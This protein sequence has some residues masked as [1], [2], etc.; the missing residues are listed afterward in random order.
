M[1]VGL[2]VPT[3]NA[4]PA[5][6]DWLAGLARQSRQPDRALVI[7]S[8]SDDDTAAL[9]RAAGLEVESIDRREFDHGGT[10]QR[11][12]DRLADCAVV[13]CLTQDAILTDPTSLA[14][15]LKV[16]D[17]PAVGAAWGRQLPHADAT[18]VAAHARAFNYPAQSRIVSYDD[19]H[20]Y[21]IKTA[22]CSN[23]FAAWRREALDA[24]GGFPSATLLAEDMFACARLLKAGWRVAYVAD[25]TVRHSHNFGWLAEFRRYFDTGATHASEDWL[26]RE[27]GNAGGEG[28]R[29][30]R[31]E[32]HFL[33]QHGWRWRL[34]AVRQLTAKWVGYKL[35]RL[36]PRLPTGLCCHLSSQPAYWLR[37]NETAQA[38]KQNK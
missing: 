2:L 1:R 22:F 33:R 18:P 23:S 13:V 27:F 32:Q 15:L 29:F 20:R 38:D 31:A 16:F 7:D 5:W 24:V 6:H 19:R 26:L 11:G 8:G 28:L 3:L 30:A 17:D 35:G 25:A 12:I 14:A 9:A 36:A 37:R 21:G 4:G 10:R 34:V